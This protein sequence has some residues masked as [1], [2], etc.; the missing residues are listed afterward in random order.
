M[1]VYEVTAFEF[2]QNHRKSIHFEDREISDAL[3]RGRIAMNDVVYIHASRACTIELMHAML[4]SS[5]T[6]DFVLI[7]YK[8][9]SDTTEFATPHVKAN[10]FHE[11]LQL[12][13]QTLTRRPRMI[14][15]Y[16]GVQLLKGFT[17]PKL[18][19]LVISMRKAHIALVT[20]CPNIAELA[21]QKISR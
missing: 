8:L 15:L 2:L 11:L 1:T 20:N 18:D 5:S 19:S 6:D 7:H 14:F 21:T 9:T 3:R 16:D 17:I 12:L 4:L 13:E 10:S